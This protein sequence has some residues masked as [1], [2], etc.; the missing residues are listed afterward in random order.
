VREIVTALQ[1]DN[2]P[3]MVL[4][5]GFGLDLSTG[6][7]FVEAGVD[8]IALAG[9]GAL[10]PATV[11]ARATVDPAYAG[12]GDV[13]S[14]WSVA[15]TDSIRHVR[16]LST[17]MP[18]VV[19]GGVRH[20]L[21]VARLVG[22]GADVVSISSPFMAAARRSTDDAVTMCRQLVTELRLAMFGVGAATVDDLRNARR[23]I[24]ET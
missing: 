1:A 14:T 12:V 16:A 2:L 24:R 7:A 15:I 5:P 21:D 6:R 19:G 20:G 18:L 4:E 17:E 23:F 22:L 8:A 10:S 13:F 3:V 11:A 9:K